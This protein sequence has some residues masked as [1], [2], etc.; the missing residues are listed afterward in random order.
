MTKKTFIDFCNI[1]IKAGDG[2][3]GHTGFRREKYVPKG[4]PDGGDGGRGGSII[5]K[6][7]EHE[8]S[9]LDYTQRKHFRAKNGQPG[10][11]RQKT[12]RSADDLVLCVP[13]GTVFR[14]KETGRPMGEIIE[15]D[16]T[17][18][19]QEGGKGG[20]GNQHFATSTNQTPRKSTPGEIREGF[21]VQMELKLL[22]D[23]GLVGFPNAGKSTFL[24]TITNAKPKIG[25]Y[26]F[27]TL[28]PCIGVSRL[29]Q[30]DSDTLI[31]SDIPGLIE[32]V[33]KGV[34]LGI[35]FLRHIQR[36]QAL[37]FILNG[38]PEHVESP[39]TQWHILQTELQNFDPTL[40]QKP[41]LI[42][43]NKIDLLPEEHIQKLQKDFAEKNLSIALISCH[44]KQG[45]HEIR[46]KLHAIV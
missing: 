29:K 30:D 16:Q 28:H 15:N 25:N 7:S 5:A 18:V 19:L 27:T 3:D 41:M 39:L 32:D 35:Q 42:A 13:L 17:L 44:N 22:A 26:A 8:F 31:I 9:L 33:H 12:G 34:G 6:G 10:G 40:M 20:L 36:T 38:D 14:N 37:L 24:S 4:G 11:R 45:I 43:L 2:G 46:E 21:W 1:F 23:I